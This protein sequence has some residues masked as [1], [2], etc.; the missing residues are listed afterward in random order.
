M[1]EPYAPA[2]PKTAAQP[3]SVLYLRL[4]HTMFLSKK[5]PAINLETTA[6]FFFHPHKKLGRAHKTKCYHAHITVEEPDA[7]GG[8]GKRED[9]SFCL[10]TLYL[11]PTLGSGLSVIHL[12]N[13]FHEQKMYFNICPV[14]PAYF[15]LEHGC[16]HTVGIRCLPRC[17]C[18]SALGFAEDARPPAARGAS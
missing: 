18:G 17:D 16:G 5:D 10:L 15:P 3:L 7:Q 14:Y 11:Q 1:G 9:P 12:L 13:F 6:F 2:P 4:A 8:P